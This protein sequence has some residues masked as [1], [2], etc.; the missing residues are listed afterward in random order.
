MTQEIY[1]LIILSFLVSVSMSAKKKYFML[2]EDDR[3][4]G[5]ERCNEIRK[6]QN[7]RSCFVDEKFYVAINLK[8][9][10]KRNLIC[11]GMLGC[12]QVEWK[13][14]ILFLVCVYMLRN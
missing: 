4:K 8:N 7:W 1:G 6:K 10:I 11:Y 9:N 13:M 3:R 14:L 2:A 5:C 12:G